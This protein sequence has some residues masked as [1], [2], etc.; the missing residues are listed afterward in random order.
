MMPT[1][2]FLA[3]RI[4]PVTGANLFHG[5]LIAGLAEW[6]NKMCRE[7]GVDVVVLSGG[8]FLNQILAEGLTTA[9]R[10]SGIISFLPHALPPND[11]GISLG[12]AWIAGN[13]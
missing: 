1:L 7:R 5:T 2:K 9:L 12:Q 8:C 6:V 4:E 3:N 11:G 10:K 13:L